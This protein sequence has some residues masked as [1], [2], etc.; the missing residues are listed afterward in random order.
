MAINTSK[1]ITSGIVA[2]IVM[3]VVDFVSNFTF[4]K[5]PTEASMNA[6]NPAL[7]QN[8]QHGAS[9]AGFVVLDFIMG[10]LLVLAYAAVR[11]RFGAGPKSA[12]IATILLWGAGCVVAGYF[13]VMGMFTPQLYW[14]T[15]VESFV[16][17]WIGAYVGGMLYREAGETAP[18]AETAMA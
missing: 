9:I 8:M 15:F 2:G 4:L 6:L 1:V 12:T 11:P 16:S 13:F 5:G 10:L 17:L 14:L 7:M 18:A 3:N